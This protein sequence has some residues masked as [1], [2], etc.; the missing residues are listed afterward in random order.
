MQITM[1][2]S[3]GRSAVK[4]RGNLRISGVASAKM[5]LVDAF[6]TSNGV[7]LDLCDIGSCDTAG[8]QVLLM[9]RASARA[10]GREF[11]IRATSVS[12]EAA[13]LQAG[14]SLESLGFAPEVSRQ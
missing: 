14:I 4:I 3:N 2:Q 1:T 9:A 5:A 10:S 13:L 8:V 6:N 11:L 12:F 7:E